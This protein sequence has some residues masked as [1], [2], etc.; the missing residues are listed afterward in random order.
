MSSARWTAEQYADY[1]RRR[2]QAE[3][4]I[5]PKVAA[6]LLPAEKESKLERRF[7][8]QLTDAGIAG[9]QRDYFFLPD[10][11]LELDFAWAPVKVY[12][13]V[14][15]MSHRIKAKFQADIEK[16]ALALFAGWRGLE[17]DGASI[18]DG[19]AIEWTKR[20]LATQI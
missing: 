19:R 8:Q 14:Q 4:D 3:R 15:G 18:R 16:R 7:A 1:E 6:R 11:E 10:R 17:I 2:G 13:E 5:T 12:V 20:L 9:Y